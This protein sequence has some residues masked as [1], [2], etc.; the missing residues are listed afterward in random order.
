MGLAWGPMRRGPESSVEAIQHGTG[1]TLRS[2]RITF[3]LPGLEEGAQRVPWAYA[4]GKVLAPFQGWEGTNGRVRG[5]GGGC[6]AGRQRATTGESLSP[7][8]GL[9][10]G[11]SV[12]RGHTPTA[13]YWRSSRAGEG[14]NGSVRGG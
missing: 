4:H 11:L 9:K 10:K 6:R 3:A 2:L 7:F 12:F 5:G 1:R 14:T 13:R 8:Q